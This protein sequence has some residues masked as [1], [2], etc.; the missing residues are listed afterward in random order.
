VFT[1]K[2]RLL[3]G[4]PADPPQ[5]VSAVPDWHVGDAVRIGA[6][7]RFT[8]TGMSYDEGTDTTTWIVMPVEKSH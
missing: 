7:H 8:I 1:F 2:M 4:S 6:E 5:F 3:D